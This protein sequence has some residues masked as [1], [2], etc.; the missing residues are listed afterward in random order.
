[1]IPGHVR[2]A[3]T[4]SAARSCRTSGGSLTVHGSSN[5]DQ[6]VTAQRHQH[7][8]AAGGR[9]H[10]R[11]DSRTSAR[12]QKSRSTRRRCRRICRPA[13]SRINFIPRDGGNRFSNSAFFTFSNSGLQGDNYSDE[14]EGRGLATPNKI[15]SNWD[16]NESFGGPIK[17]DKVWFWF[18]TRYN[19]VAN[20]AADLRERERLQGERVAL[21]ARRRQP[22]VN[23]GSSS[24]TASA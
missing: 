21:R 11:P 14:L 7:D 2:A 1:M 24:T 18:S 23:E 22:G 12:R 8:D 17:R 3:A 9:Q 20:E 10:R 4:T 6:R 16:L 13:A 19:A 5:T 15:A